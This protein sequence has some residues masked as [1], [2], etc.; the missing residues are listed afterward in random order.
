MR[1]VYGQDPVTVQAQTWNPSWSMYASDANVAALIT[2]DSGMIVNYQGTWQGNWSRP[3]FEWRTDCTEGV[4][5][6]H[7]QFG[8]LSYAR[9]DELDSMPVS[10]PPHEMWI[11]ETVNLWDAF[12]NTVVD[13]EPLQCSGRDHLMS[14]AVLEACIRSSRERRAV[15]IAEILD[16]PLIRK[17]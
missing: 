15:N 12:L 6:Q 5:L 13:G 17:P 2:F 16:M 7:D 1:Y 9:R 8:A 3:N 11:S 10:L 4:I 14:L